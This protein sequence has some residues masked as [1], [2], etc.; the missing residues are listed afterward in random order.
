M[1]KT[2]SGRIVTGIMMATTSAVAMLAGTSAFAQTVIA[3]GDNMTVITDMDGQ[4]INVAEGVT[5][6]T[7]AAPVVVFHNAD[8]TLN[9]NGVLQK[10]G[11]AQAVYVNAAAP[12][13]TINNGMTGRISGDSRA[14]NL[15]GASV[16]LNNHGHITGTGDQRNG[17]VFINPTANMAVINNS[18]TIDAGEGNSGSGITANLS[19]NGSYFEIENSGVIAGRGSAMAGAETAGD[20]IRFERGRVNGALDGSTTGLFTG[21]IVNTGH[22]TSE[23]TSGTTAAI[24]FVNGVSFQGTLTNGADGVIHGTQNGLY[25]GNPVPA[26]GSDHSGGVVNN[27]G[28]ISSDSRALNID[29]IGL[30]VNNFGKIIG[31]GDQRNGTIFVDNTANHFTIYNGEDGV[32]DTGMGNNGSAISISLGVSDGDE[33]SFEIVNDGSIWGRGDAVN[34]GAS[35]GLRLYNGAGVDAYVTVDAYIENNGTIRSDSSAAILIDDVD[36]QGILINNGTLT[37]V[38]SFNAK[39]A[40]SGIYFVQTGGALNGHFVGSDFDDTLEFRGGSSTLAGNV[41]NGVSVLVKEDAKLAVSGHRTLDGYLENSGNL[42]FKLGSDSLAV[43]GDVL[44]ADGSVITIDAS[45]DSLPI[46]TAINIITNGGNFVNAG[47]TV[48]IVDT[49]FLVDYQ[50][51]FGSLSITP[52]A[53]ALGN[54][55]ADANINAFGAAITRAVTAN[56]LSDDVFAALNGASNA[57]AFE[58]VALG[59]LP[60]INEGVTREIYETQNI[61]DNLV[62]ERLFSGQGT[63]IWGQII[64]RTSDR[65]G[66]SL[67]VSGYDADSFGFTLG[68]DVAASENIRIGV[69]FTYADLDIDQNG[70]GLENISV[71]AYQVSGYLGYNGDKFFVNALIGYSFNDVSSE[72]SSAA[73]RITADYDVD[74]LRAQVNAGYDLGND[75]FGITPYVGLAYARLSPDSYT[76]TGGL[77]LH[78]NAGNSDFVEGK[79]GTRFTTKRSSGVGFRGNLA[80]VYD[81]DGDARR[82]NLNFDGAG[83]PVQLRTRGEAESRFEFGA[84]LTY[85]EERGISIALDY[86][87]ELASGYDSHAGIFRIRYGF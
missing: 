29:G 74:G 11:G 32:V 26:G 56:T 20:G 34:D 18:G 41:A 5:S 31:T 39:T 82:F 25:F 47:T 3:D 45:N 63:G 35:A 2:G 21:E 43:T 83:T 23:S 44:L 17:T 50:V 24:R 68:A 30:E 64:G 52:I 48:N 80:Y 53:V 9:N 62:T 58:N 8:V 14:I 28:R 38:N 81:F 15:G 75:N 76:E 40:R 55:S 4:T 27:H 7:S 86:Q 22:I 46:G 65:D 12:N 6:T 42:A 54:V 77:D 84:G 61:A 10:T 36:F 1:K 69:A 16:I 66:E 72:R 49:N 19:T 78:V 57:A 59:L 51:V 73:G 13:A 60:S 37:G 87:G 85:G 71:D 67:S 70:G 79:I 33:R